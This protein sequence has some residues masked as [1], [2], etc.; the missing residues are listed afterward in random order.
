LE[1]NIKKGSQAN[2][3]NNVSRCKTLSPSYVQNIMTVEFVT[4]QKYKPKYY[5]I[6]RATQSLNFH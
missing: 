4:A 1:K 2:K 5:Q 3:C 6:N